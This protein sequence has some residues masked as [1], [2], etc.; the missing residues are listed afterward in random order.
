M[1]GNTREAQDG[2]TALFFTKGVKIRAREFLKQ[3]AAHKNVTWT[4]VELIWQHEVVIG[5]ATRELAV[6][7]D[8]FA[9]TDDFDLHLVTDIGTTTHE[10]AGA[11][12]TKL[13]IFVVAT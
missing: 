9:F 2:T 13:R 7:R 8:L 11:E 5:I 4:F 1:R 12:S 10:M 3:Q 6:E